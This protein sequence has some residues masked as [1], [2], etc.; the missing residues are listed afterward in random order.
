V[1]CLLQKNP[2][3]KIVANFV[4]LENLCEMQTLLKELESKNMIK[5][6]EITQLQVSKA[7]KLGNFNLMKAQNPVFIVSFEGSKKM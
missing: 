4:S 2:F 1:N 5:K 7:A 3:V 6:L